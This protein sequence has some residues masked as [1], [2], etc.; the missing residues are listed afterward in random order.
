MFLNLTDRIMLLDF[1]RFEEFQE[2]SSKSRM[3]VGVQMFLA[4]GEY[5]W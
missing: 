5:P 2:C 3:S 4:L 1:L